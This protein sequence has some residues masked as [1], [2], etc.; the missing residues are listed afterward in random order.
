[1]AAANRRH[2]QVPKFYLGRFARDGKVVVRRRDGTTFV[3]NPVNVAVET[4]YYDI[5]DGLGGISK[6]VEAG[7]ADIEGMTEAVLR[8]VDR[9]DRLP[10]P[11]NRDSATLALFVG[12]QVARTTQHR[13]RVLFPRRVVD[14]ASG[15]AITPDLVAEFLETQYLGFEPDR[16][17]VEAAYAIV[18]LA[19]Q[20]AHLLTDEFAVEMMLRAAAGI[21]TRLL[22]LNWSLEFD[23]KRAFITSD[24]PVVLWRKPA[25]RDD[26]RG[27]GVE[28]AAEVRLP[29]DPGKQ[30]VM[31]RRQRRPRLDVSQHRVRRANAEMAAACH[32]F[33]IGSPDNRGEMEAQRLDAWRPVIRFHQGP[34]LEEGPDGQVLPS[35]DD[36]I[37]MWTPRDSRAGRPRRPRA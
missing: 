31:S 15:R 17:E 32:R 27:I 9:D 16:A 26:F 34:V 12:L 18:S 22:G 20:D 36:V 7:L 13:E 21:S 28:T 4:G 5:P 23:R 25:R 35:G 11:T 8:V 10:E 37:H 14:W 19:V 2:H 24:S 29:L 33:I 30:L 6:E 3:S 1:M